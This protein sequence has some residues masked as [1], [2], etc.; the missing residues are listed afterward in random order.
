M[1]SNAA[2]TNMLPY[3]AA[4]STIFRPATS[5]GVRCF[6]QPAA[7]SLRRRTSAAS[8]RPP[9]ATYP[10]FRSHARGS[11]PLGAG[12]IAVPRHPAEDGLDLE[13]ALRRRPKGEEDGA[14]E[15]DRGH[16]EPGHAIVL[17]LT[18]RRR[19][20]APA[21]IIASPTAIRMWPVRVV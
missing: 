18:M 5:S 11:E 8:P 20:S 10:I 19:I 2:A 17:G 7:A 6:D 14:A 12:G 3:A 15:Q 16:Q 9:G 21:V 1:T 4:G 13:P